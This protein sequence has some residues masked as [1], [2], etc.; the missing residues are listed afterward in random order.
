MPE[1]GTPKWKREGRTG[2]GPFAPKYTSRK[3]RRQVRN[4]GGCAVLVFGAIATVTG[5][6]SAV[7]ATLIMVV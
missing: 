6:S 3:M 2:P 5:A 7:I 4:D 1:W